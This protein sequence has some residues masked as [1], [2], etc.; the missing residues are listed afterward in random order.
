MNLARRIVWRA[1]NLHLIVGA[2]CSRFISGLLNVIGWNWTIKG[3]VSVSGQAARPAP[4][5]APLR[6]A[7]LL[8]DDDWI[9]SWRSLLFFPSACILL[10][11]FFD[12]ILDQSSLYTLNN[13]C[14]DKGLHRNISSRESKC[15]TFIFLQF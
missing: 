13:K 7:G 9:Q 2:Q 5:T 3:P 1:W 15:S 8:K 4:L 10:Y 11:A 12:T 14:L 6:G